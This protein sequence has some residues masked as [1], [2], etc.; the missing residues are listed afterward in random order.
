MRILCFIFLFSG[1]HSFFLGRS[2]NSR[3]GVNYLFLQSFPEKHRIT[4]FN[5]IPS[6]KHLE[7]NIKKDDETE[8]NN[9]YEI[10]K[11][12]VGYLSYSDMEKVRLSLV[13]SY[14]AHYNQKR[15][16]RE[17]FIIH[18]LSVAII[19]SESKPDVDTLI[20]GLLHDTVEDTN[21]TFS[22]IECVFGENVRRIVEGVTKAT[23]C[24]NDNE[25]IYEVNLRS[26]FLSMKDDWRII[27]VKLADRLH[28]MRTIEYMRRD[29]RIR[30]S[31]ETLEIYSPLAHRIGMW[32]IRNELEDLSFKSLEPI[33][34][35]QV[36]YNRTKKVQLYASKIEGLQTKMDDI[37]T[38]TIPGKYKLEYRTKSVYS[39][40]KK[41][42]RYN[43]GVSDLKDLIALRIIIN[44]DWVFHLSETIGVCFIL[45]SKIHSIWKYIPGTVKDYIHFPKPNGYQSLHTTILID[46]NL[47]LEIQIRTQKMHNI[48]EYGTAAHWKYK[49]NKTNGRSVGWLDIF[50]EWDRTNE[51]TDL[52]KSVLKLPV[53]KLM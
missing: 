25:N 5:K 42:E 17:R 30:I 31:N 12:H 41:T 10:L 38:K 51:K 35:Y 29:K 3:L 28:N 48:A 20:G 19:L 24:A 8:L 18:P 16:S 33:K 40:W 1:A 13:V 50:D 11:M 34:Y 27:L 2:I 47:P 45:L 15:E 53:T 21:V 52:I 49:S 9:L 43:C 22:E 26:M 44:E 14:Y 37:L 6:L 32:N 4:L 46:N 7:K 23:N 36:V 39:A